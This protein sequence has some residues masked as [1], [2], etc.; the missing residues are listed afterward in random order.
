MACSALVIFVV[1][2]N[3]HAMTTPGGNRE[4]ELVA[5]EER[6]GRVP[7]DTLAVRLM[8]AR[9]LAGHLSIREAADLCGVGR[10][11]WTKWERGTRPSDP[12]ET[13]P[14]IAEKLDVDEHWLMWGGPLEG[15]HGRVVTKRPGTVRRPY[16]GAATR[17]TLDRPKV[18]EDPARPIY[19]Q[20]GQGRRANRVN[21]GRN[22]DAI[23][24]A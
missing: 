20:V 5:P 8:L 24:A 14:L 22:A 2:G 4:R 15:P 6:R 12:L 17:P 10:G 1:S 7:A 21:T 9:T 16:I 18:R 23:Y 19:A 11:A 3:T 13:L